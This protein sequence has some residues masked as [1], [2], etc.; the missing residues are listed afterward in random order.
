MNLDDLTEPQY[1]ICSDMVEIFYRQY[2]GNLR[3]GQSFFNFY[4]GTVFNEP[5]PELFYCENENKTKEMME[6]CLI[7]YITEIFK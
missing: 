2:R 5:Y 1:K 7:N 6:I 3:L 4:Y